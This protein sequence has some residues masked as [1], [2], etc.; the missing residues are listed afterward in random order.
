M[1]ETGSAF[2]WNSAK[3]SLVESLWRWVQ[4]YELKGGACQGQLCWTPILV[5][6][7]SR[8]SRER[9]RHGEKLNV[10]RCRGAYLALALK[11]VHTIALPTSWCI[12]ERKQICN[13]LQEDATNNVLLIR[14]SWCFFQWHREIGSMPTCL[15]GV[16]GDFFFFLIDNSAL[17]NVF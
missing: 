17:A 4:P 9:S 1:E 7:H 10:H 11:L 13:V 3:G 8:S 15:A 5:H 6:G 2:L 16:S 12:S 14:D